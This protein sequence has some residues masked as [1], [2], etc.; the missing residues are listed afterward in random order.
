MQHKN[1]TNRNLSSCRPNSVLTWRRMACVWLRAQSQPPQRLW[2][3]YLRCFPVTLFPF[4]EAGSGNVY[5]SLTLAFSFSSLDF[6]LF[7]LCGPHSCSKLL[8]ATGQCFP[9]HA[10]LAG[11]SE[12]WVAIQLPKNPSKNLL[13]IILR[14]WPKSTI[15]RSPFIE[16]Y[17][18]ILSIFDF[19]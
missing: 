11:V 3:I 18:G 17:A 2:T 13:Q 5:G 8:G 12:N 1:N 14:Y 19:Q 10:E 6:L 16:I 15:N 7:G 4:G 9:L